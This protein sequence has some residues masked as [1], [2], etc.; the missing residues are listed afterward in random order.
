[1]SK[2]EIL[3][4]VHTHC[5]D[6]LE[7]MVR[8]DDALNA[9]TEYASQESISAYNKA[10]QEAIEK[11]ESMI[12]NTKRSSEADIFYGI[13]KAAQSLESLKITVDKV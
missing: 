4:K 9:M 11:L 6:E 3:F 2:E 12:N 8:Y 7:M 13:E 5:G 1:M 10:I